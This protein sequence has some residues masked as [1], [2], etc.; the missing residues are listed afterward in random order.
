MSMYNELKIKGTGDHNL[1]D[2]YKIIVYPFDKY[3]IK[4]KLSANDKFIEIVEIKI[5]KQFLS[6]RQRISSTGFHDVD[7]FY[8]E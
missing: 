3:E 8:R 7:E 2:D 6:H 4:I 1:D 5:S